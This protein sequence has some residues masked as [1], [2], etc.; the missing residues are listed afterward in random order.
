MKYGRWCRLGRLW[1]Y[2]P[3]RSDGFSGP[4]PAGLYKINLQLNPS[5][6]ASLAADGSNLYS[7][8]GVQLIRDH[9]HLPDSNSVIPAGWGT[10]RARLEKV[11]VN[12]KRN[13]FYLHN[14][15]KGYTHG[16][17]ET[18]DDLYD[19]FSKYHQQGLGSILVNIRY[20]TDSTNGGTRQ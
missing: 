15:T 13:N 5:R 20:T 11:K 4:V 9:Y 12:S 1:R 7:N 6:F 17:V 19:R 2:A 3:K 18:C 10:W 8:F 14:S 16:C